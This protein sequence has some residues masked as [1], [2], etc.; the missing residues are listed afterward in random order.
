MF[1]VSNKIRT[2]R[3]EIHGSHHTQPFCLESSPSCKTKLRQSGFWQTSVLR[4]KSGEELSHLTV[5]TGL[6]LHEANVLV[7][8]WVEGC[9]FPSEV[10]PSQVLKPSLNWWLSNEVW[11]M[12]VLRAALVSSCFHSHCPVLCF[13]F[14]WVSYETFICTTKC[15]FPLDMKCIKFQYPIFHYNVSLFFV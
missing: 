15:T 3:N 7:C 1:E 13:I 10:V 12:S 2:S 5:N 8:Y 14:S 6:G 9:N 4:C 11:R